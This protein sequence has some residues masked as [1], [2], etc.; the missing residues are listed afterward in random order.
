MTLNACMLIFGLGYELALG[1]PSANLGAGFA[2]FVAVFAWILARF[3]RHT[4]AG[5]A[6]G[7]W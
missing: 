3:A 6:S 4:G 2:C 7:S 1:P 5:L